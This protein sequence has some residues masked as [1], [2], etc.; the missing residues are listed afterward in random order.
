MA[1]QVKRDNSLV[2]GVVSQFSTISGDLVSMA[3]SEHS[4]SEMFDG[5]CVA[6]R[7]WTWKQSTAASV[8]SVWF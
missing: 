6:A 7:V 5:K 2:S 8:R 1:S 4:D 3:L